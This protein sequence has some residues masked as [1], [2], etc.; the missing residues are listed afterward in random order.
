LISGGHQS[1][2]MYWRNPSTYINLLTNQ[3][4]SDNTNLLMTA[5]DC[6]D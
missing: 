2:Q 3:T 5:N 6:M 1:T 4:L